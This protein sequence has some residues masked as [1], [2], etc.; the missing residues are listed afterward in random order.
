[1][2]GGTRVAATTAALAADRVAGDVTIPFVAVTASR[3]V[4]PTSAS[5]TT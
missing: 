4:E 1:V 3:S 5:V 2:V